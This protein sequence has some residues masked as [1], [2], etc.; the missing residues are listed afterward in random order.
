[1][2]FKE[3]SAKTRCTV[4]GFKVL[5]NVLDYLV[6]TLSESSAVVSPIV[7]IWIYKPSSSNSSHE[8]TWSSRNL[9]PNYIFYSIFHAVTS[10]TSQYYDIK[11]YKRIIPVILLKICML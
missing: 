6:L 8:L 1:M 11:V 2:S 5:W 4:C 9:D 3:R 10:F 7:F